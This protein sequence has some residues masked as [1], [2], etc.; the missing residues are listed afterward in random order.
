MD[1]EKS[2]IRADLIDIG[3]YFCIFDIVI[4]RRREINRVE[5]IERYVHLFNIKAAP[6]GLDTYF[7]H[8]KLRTYL[9]SEEIRYLRN[10]SSNS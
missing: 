1:R 7:W 8:R 2:N 3:M 5:E 4:K 9:G 6:F 10:F